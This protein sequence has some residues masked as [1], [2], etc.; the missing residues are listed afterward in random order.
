MIREGKIYHPATY[1]S[2]LDDSIDSI[3][4]NIKVINVGLRLVGHLRS[5]LTLGILE[6][7]EKKWKIDRVLVDHFTRTK[8]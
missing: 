5:I 4:I 3:R 6:L 8:T 2:I 7:L 1:I